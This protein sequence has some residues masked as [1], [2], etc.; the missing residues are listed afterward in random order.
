MVDRFV[1]KTGQTVL[2][3]NDD[4]SEEGSGYLNLKDSE[5]YVLFCRRC[6]SSFEGTGDAPR[7]CQKCQAIE[8]DIYKD[9]D[10]KIQRINGVEDV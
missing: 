4:N 7:A 2:K 1:N 9:V 6:N 10:G 3:I 5:A 8:I